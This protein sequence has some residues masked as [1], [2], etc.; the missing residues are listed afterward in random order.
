MACVIV[1]IRIGF[2]KEW[3]CLVPVIGC[4]G[5]WECFSCRVIEVGISPRVGIEA[6]TSPRVGI[7]MSVYPRVG[8][9]METRK[10]RDALSFDDRVD[11]S[12]EQLANVSV[13]GVNRPLHP[14]GGVF[15]SV[16]PDSGLLRDGA[17]VVPGGGTSSRFGFWW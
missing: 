5:F 3:R 14:S 6:G 8:I 10:K 15:G 2:I 7:E 16:F 11:S 12:L 17:G 1:C 4:I 9:E 13:S